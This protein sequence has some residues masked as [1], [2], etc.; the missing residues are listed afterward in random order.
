MVSFLTLMFQPLVHD[1]DLLNILLFACLSKVI[2]LYHML[3]LPQSYASAIFLLIRYNVCKL[4]FRMNNIP[5]AEILFT[6]RLT[7]INQS[8]NVSGQLGDKPFRHLFHYILFFLLIESIAT[9]GATKFTPDFQWCSCCSIIRFQC[10]V[11]QIVVCPFSFGHGAVCPSNTY[12]NY[13]FVIF[14]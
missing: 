7:T 4:V 2:L 12:S 6:W 5:V 10:S 3:F 11:L 9:S 8:I 14:F 13:P 1:S